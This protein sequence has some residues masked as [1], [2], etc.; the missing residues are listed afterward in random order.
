MVKDKIICLATGK[1][2]KLTPEE[3]VRQDYIKILIE[4]YGYKK[5]D[6]KIE[7]PVKR[8]PSDTRKSLPVDI[9]VMENNK[10]KIFIETKKPT[11]KEGIVQLKNYMDFEDIR[12]GVWTNG[13]LEEDKISIHYVEKII[14]GGKIEYKDIFDIPEKGFFSTKEQ[15][16]KSELKPTSNLKNIFKQMRGFIAANATGTTRDEKILSELMA[17]LMCKIYDE[18]YKMAE[19]Y[20]DFIVIDDDAHKTATRIKQIFKEKVKVK[21]PMVFTEKDEINLDDN[22]I[23][24]VVAQLQRYCLIG[25][26]HQVVSDAFESIISYASKGSQGQF[27]TP[28][29]VIDLMVNFLKPERY[30]TMIDIA[31]G[32]SGFITSTMNYVWEEI[33]SKRMEETAKAEEK[34][35]YAMTQLFGIEKDD[36]LAK[37]SKAYMAILGDGKAGIFIE[38]SLNKKYWSENAKAKVRNDYFDYVLTNPPFGKDVKVKKETKDLYENDSVN[39]IFL[40]RA[41]QVLKDKGILGIILPETVFHSSS[42][43]NIRENLFYKHNIL[44]IIDLPHDTF[45]PFNNAKCDVIFLQKN[46]P[47]QDKILAINVENIGHNHLGQQVF[48]YDIDTNTF[49]EN[50]VNDDIPNLIELLK[51]ENFMN[52]IERECDSNLKLNTDIKQIKY[53][54][55]QDVISSDLLVA[56]NYFEPQINIEK[57]VTL[58]KLIE[59]KIV[60]YF[61]GHGSP[62][63]HLKGV[64]NKPYIRVKDIVNME[65]YI[66]PLDKIPQFEYER[67][68]SKKK[69][70]KERDIAFVRRGS[71][72]IGDVGILYK[73]DL[74]SIFTR[75]ILILRIDKNNKGEYDNEYNLT[76][77]NLLYL[78]N[79]EEVRKQLKN[80]IMFDTTLPNIA[81]RWKNLY[82]PIYS[83]EKMKELSKKMEELYNMR[84]DFWEKISEIEI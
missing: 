23:I 10:P 46:V 78:L 73:K 45:R 30:K 6:I 47:Q 32:T 50:E 74:E 19:D 55:A 62:K 57:S 3:R 75:E 83:E 12:Y 18:R 7:Y 63:A 17:I 53:V 21:Y 8:S 59:Q 36:F 70:L 40:E 72:R 44:C 64:G 16:K 52:N 43:K 1:E 66:N 67:L 5:E 61:D 22:S 68:F 77:F 51:N 49:D 31:C 26:K 4:D 80:K 42:N 20:M 25:T 2:L 9:V 54:K 37:I 29:N 13:N 82:I 15:I 69:T 84:S 65:V 39:I 14:K 48:K 38:D 27:F 35:E 76:P 11:V 56:R 41:L 79:S 33:D 71:Y 58:E 34:K 81:D 24:H 60:K 28:K